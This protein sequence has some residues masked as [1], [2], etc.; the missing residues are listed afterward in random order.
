MDK[1]MQIG[2]SKIVD[3]LNELGWAFAMKANTAE[4]ESSGPF[5]LGS[6]KEVEWLVESIDTEYD[7][8]V[9]HNDFPFT[10]MN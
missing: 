9:K 2:F 7:I 6:L 8:Y 10:T 5:I 1:R 4:G 3:G